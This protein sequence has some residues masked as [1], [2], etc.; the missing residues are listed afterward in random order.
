MEGGDS[1]AFFGLGVKDVDRKR[2]E[3]GDRCGESV[4]EVVFGGSFWMGQKSPAT[5]RSLP[6]GTV[7][8]MTSVLWS[9]R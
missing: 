5:V 3:V 7:S 9:M 1:V 8:G 2:G 4:A 6:A